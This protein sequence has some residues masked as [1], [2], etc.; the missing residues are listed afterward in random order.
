MFNAFSLR[1]GFLIGHN[2]V[3]SQALN[4]EH[5]VLYLHLLLLNSVIGGY[6]TLTLEAEQGLASSDWLPAH[7]DVSGFVY[8]N[9][10]F[11]I[12]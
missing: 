9:V 7:Q 1:F 12:D 5:F 4:F 3:N 11:V 10:C 2:F 6:V 8:F